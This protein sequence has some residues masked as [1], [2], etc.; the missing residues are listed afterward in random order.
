V[1]GDG[2]HGFAALERSLRSLDANSL[3]DP[4]E[5]MKRMAANAGRPK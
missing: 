1:G 2:G 3:V 5:M 4:D